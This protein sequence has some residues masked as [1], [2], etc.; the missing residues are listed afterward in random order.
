MNCTQPPNVE[1]PTPTW[2]SWIADGVILLCRSKQRS[3]KVLVRLLVGS[4]VLAAA[5][6]LSEPR[7]GWCPPLLRLAQLVQS[8]ILWRLCF[9]LGL[10]ALVLIFLPNSKT[11]GPAA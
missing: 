3:I 8:L 11:E 2:K 5:A 10:P 1:L 9:A 6:I 4:L 7:L